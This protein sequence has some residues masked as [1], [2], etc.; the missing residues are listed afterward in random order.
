LLYRFVAVQQPAAADYDSRTR[1]EEFIGNLA[2]ALEAAPVEVLTNGR[3]YIR[4]HYEAL[5]D[6]RA[7]F[8]DRLTIRITLESPEPVG[9]DRLRGRGTF[10]QT[11]DTIVQLSAMGFTPVVTAERDF[12]G[13]RSDDEI[14][15]EYHALFSARGVRVEVNLIENVMEMGFE[16]VRL[17]QEG[18]S[19]APEVFVTTDCFGALQRR[20]ETLMCHFS[21]CLQKIDGELRYYPCPVIYDDPHFELGRSLA[22]SLRR[23]YIAHKNCYGYCLKGR[24]GSCRTSPI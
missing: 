24:G 11:V 6:L 12:L 17:V 16:L 2:C 4:N 22:E 3:K 23:V 18:K 13:T 19:P 20:P 15:D 21:R 8:R 5:R 14:R 10:H 7:R 9:H 1:N